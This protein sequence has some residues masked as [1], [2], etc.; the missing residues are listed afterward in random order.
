MGV[1]YLW[2]TVGKKYYSNTRYH[3]FSEPKMTGTQEYGRLV[4]IMTLIKNIHLN[5]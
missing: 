4:F 1:K 2:H 5:K 3:L